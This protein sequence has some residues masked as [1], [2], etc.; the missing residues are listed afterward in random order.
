[1]T[2]APRLAR[3]LPSSKTTAVENLSEA[4]RLCGSIEEI[5][6]DTI[7]GQIDSLPVRV[8][9]SGFKVL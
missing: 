9:W 5:T 8:G 2:S 1:M 7:I 4:D 3:R 6:L